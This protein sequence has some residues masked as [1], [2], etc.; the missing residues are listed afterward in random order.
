[1]NFF[2][3]STVQN[4]LTVIATALLCYSGSAF[5]FAQQDA[6]A[7]EQDSL[8]EEVVVTGSRRDPRTKFESASPVDV[9]SQDDFRQQ[10]G[11][12]L[13]DLLRNTIPSFNANT[14]PIS[15][16]STVIR[17][18][19]LRGLAP[20]HTLVLV[21]SK[22]WHRSAVI[23]W[24]GNGVSDGSQGPDLSIIPAI[25]LK[26]LE[27]LRDGA[28]AQYGSDAIAGVMNFVLKDYSDGVE[29]EARYGL[30]TE[31]D[32]NTYR[33]AANIGLPITDSGYLNLSGEF[34]HS[35]PTDRGEQRGD[36]QALLDAGN[37]DVNSPAQVW[38][39][40][41]VAGDLKT[42]YNFGLSLS[43]DLKVYSFGNFARRD[44]DGGFY[45][46]NPNTRSGVFSG[47][48]GVT[49]LVAD[50]D[51]DGDNTCAEVPVN[52][53]DG[54]PNV[55]GLQA[56]IDD[57]NCFVFNELFPGGFTP[58]FGGTTVDY[59][60]LVGVEGQIGEFNW[61]LSGHT[62]SSDADFF[63]NNTVNASLGADTPTD[64]DPGAYTQVE[65]GI[66]LD[67]SIALPVDY[68]ASDLNVAF[69]F[70][71]RDEEFE[72]TRGQTESFQRGPFAEQGFSV[73]SNG[74]PG[75]SDLAAGK[76]NR[77]NIALYVD[78]EADILDEWTLGLAVRWE[79]YDD[80]GSTFNGKISTHIDLIEGVAFR[81]TYS[82]GFKAPTPGQSNAFNVTTE[83]DPSIGMLVNRGTVPATNG[84]AVL[85][86]GEQLTPEK[87]VGVTT[88]FVFE[89]G[90][91]QLSIDYFNIE[92]TDR[93]ALS[94]DFSLTDEERVALVASGVTGSDTLVSFRFF[95]N[96]F[97]TNTQGLDLVGSF[98]F[99]WDL[100]KT[101]LKAAFNHTLTRVDGL[102]DDGGRKRELEEGL[103][104]N[105]LNLSVTHFYN[106]F[107]LS[108]R[109]NYY[110]SWLDSEDTVDSGLVDTDGEP[111]SEP[112][113]YP[114]YALV[115]LELSYDFTLNI[116]LSLGI[117]NVFDTRPQENPDSLEGNPNG[118]AGRVYSQ[119][120]PGGFNGRF[121]YARAV[122]RI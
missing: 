37:T 54:T 9:I 53:A 28:A 95:T 63:I 80:F 91:F 25:A 32:G 45:F 109:Y 23:S 6:D 44:T 98:D 19:N 112:I 78:V 119:F 86:G 68:F 111:I 38:G 42:F 34:G 102:E 18:A 89:N 72:I 40:P 110:S 81:A 15:D 92:V 106:S 59:S 61:D 116:N 85:R 4:N 76:W 21:N 82:T 30:Y 58:R 121:V 2:K 122:Y 47:D 108:L 77:S 50:L 36:A 39:S 88:G 5:V 7:E 94:Q 99:D 57:P 22:R 10:G 52:N 51:F 46:R 48:G 33:I 87:S 17:P 12:D 83:F 105:R 27:V 93:L 35:D 65:T 60:I 117:D 120:A 14:Q 49:R 64:F 66:N 74:F 70:E 113:T 29:V 104:H 79:D 55:V 8:I 24:L 1:M 26:Q 20:D 84:A 62:A 90:G 13:T 73:A 67:A 114:A 56:V 41:E 100:G 3:L 97:D 107:R 101:S 103:P 31:G 69:G 16:A 96:D 75:F 43:E 118:F 11:S 115:G 71:W